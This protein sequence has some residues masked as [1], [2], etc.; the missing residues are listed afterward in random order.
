MIRVVGSRELGICPAQ[1]YR[2]DGTIEINRDVWN[3]YNE[4]DQKFIIEH[5]RGHYILQT[6]SETDA[7]AYALRRLYG[8]AP[9]SLKRSLRTL[10]RLPI[11]DYD[12]K[13]AL[14]IEALRIDAKNNN[15]EAINELIKLNAMNAKQS[16]GSYPFIVKNR[17]TG[18]ETTIPAPETPSPETPS[19]QSE[20]SRLPIIY[21]G[22]GAGYRGI[23]IGKV[24]LSFE[25]IL[26]AAILFMLI[27]N[28]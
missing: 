22:N 25:T 17:T 23:R 1:V 4:F 27:R 3:R 14:Y 24:L 13:K 19:P 18:N 8:T 16:T 15:K 2:S 28:N 11:I 26:L 10:N 7:D 5:E 20:P 6:D 12:R 9:Q 21:I